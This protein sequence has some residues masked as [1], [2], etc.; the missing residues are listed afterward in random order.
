MGGQSNGLNSSLIDELGYFSSPF[1]YVNIGRG[2]A[3]D[4]LVMKSIHITGL[5]NSSYNLD[6]VC[7]LSYTKT[8]T[9]DIRTGALV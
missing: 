5:N 6:L 4:D 7:F 2:L 1:I 9:I 3:S 8:F